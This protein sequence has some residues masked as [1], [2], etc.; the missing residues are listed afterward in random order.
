ML[1]KHD[2]LQGIESGR[3]E[4]VFRKWSQPRVRAG[5]TLRTAVGVLEVLAVEA[6]EPDTLNSSDADAAGFGSVAEL[7]SSAGHRGGTLYRVRLRHV[8]PD[9]RVSLRESIPDE[10]ERDEIGARLDRLDAV[11]R[12]GP[13]AWQTLELIAKH[14]G[15][16][17]EDLASLVGRQKKPFKLDVRK[18]KEL[19]LTESLE[20]GYR[21]S[22][23]GKT[24][25]NNRR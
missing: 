15:V 5:S 4:A 11:S 17:A 14:P 22:P 21:L 19:G 13:R 8:G 6:V 12:H 25:I 10:S 18:L 7:M 3:I 20:T 9:P 24:V 16:R 23:R 1:L 2:V